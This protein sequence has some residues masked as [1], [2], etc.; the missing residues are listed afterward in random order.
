MKDLFVLTADADMQAVFRAVLDRS[1]AL[2]IRRI[3]FEVDRHPNRDSGAFTDGPELLRTK[4]KSDFR[5]FIV[6]FDHH[7]SGCNSEPDDCART[8][9]DRLDSFTF[10]DYSMVVVIA[11]ELEEWLWCHPSAIGNAQELGAIADPK[12]RLHQVFLRRDKRKP[13][14][15]DYEA[16]STRADLQAWSSSPSFRVLKETLQNWFPIA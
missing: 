6:A 11:P 16:I 15:R 10:K 2:G 12:E 7:G 8:V 13:R 1:D 9:Q 14:P 5:H 3:S 4:P